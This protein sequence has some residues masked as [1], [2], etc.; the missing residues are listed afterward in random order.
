MDNVGTQIS[1]S[2]DIS[3]SNNNTHINQNEVRNI[4]PIKR[5]ST[6][7]TSSIKKA[8]NQRINKNNLK[9][10]IP[11]INSS[12]NNIKKKQSINNKNNKRDITPT[13]KFN[14]IEK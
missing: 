7:S 8:N 12:S 10:L 9:N 4:E 14:N 1:R 5:I 11:K 2:Q 13:N 6:N 3:N